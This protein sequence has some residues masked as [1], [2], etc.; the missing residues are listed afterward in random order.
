MR[1][2]VF[3]VNSF[4]DENHSAGARVALIVGFHESKERFS[5]KIVERVRSSSAANSLLHNSSVNF[6]AKCSRANSR[7]SANLTERD[8]VKRNFQTS[9]TGHCSI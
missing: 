8:T 1:V 6:H 3:K 4:R 2:S 5:V 7:S 9:A